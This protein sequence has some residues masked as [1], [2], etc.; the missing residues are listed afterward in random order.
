MGIEA[1]PL[2]KYAP[3]C[4]YQQPLYS[5]RESYNISRVLRTSCTLISIS[6]LKQ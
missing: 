3:T 4:P 6:K 5:I 1:K 2:A